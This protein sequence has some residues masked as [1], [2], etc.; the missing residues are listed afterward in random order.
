MILS[1][2]LEVQRVLVKR[3]KNLR[4]LTK[5]H[6]D[7]EQK[8]RNLKD[9][10]TKAHLSGLITHY[11]R[12]PLYCMSPEEENEVLIKRLSEIHTREYREGYVKHLSENPT[13]YQY[14]SQKD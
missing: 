8:Y 10:L 13:Q 7:L 2:L 3:E 5:Q 11:E 1:I 12:L 6:R 9:H 14:Y 4:N